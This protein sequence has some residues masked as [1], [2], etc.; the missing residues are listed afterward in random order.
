MPV[1]GFLSNGSLE[2]SRDY[3]AAFS[4]GLAKTGNIEGRNFTIEHRW[5]DGRIEPLPVMAAELV[6]RRVAVIV[7]VYT[8]AAVAAKAATQ[9]I[10]VIVLIGA[11]PVELGLVQSFAHPGGNVTGVASLNKTLTEKRLELLRDLLPA[12]KTIGYLFNPTSAFST[13]EMKAAQDAARVAGV[14]LLVAEATGVRDFD[15]AFKT[16]ATVDAVLVSGDGLFLG[17]EIVASANHAAVPAIYT[18]RNSVAGGGL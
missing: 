14:Q 12:A 5:T 8:P 2:R 11:D 3:L 15:R 10:P 16:L 4:S 18:Y 9:T 13:Y 7:T 6:A 17:P 1:I